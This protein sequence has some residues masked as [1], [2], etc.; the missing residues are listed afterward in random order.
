LL[1]ELDELYELANVDP[2]KRLALLESRHD[3]VKSRNESFVREIMVLVLVGRYDQAIAHLR[4][5]FFHIRE[6]GGEIHDV[7]VDAHLLRGL[8]RLHAG[9]HAAALRDFEA[10]SE[11]PQNLS[12]GRP[13]RDRRAPQV[14]YLNGLAHQALGDAESA[15][16]RFRAAVEQEGTREAATQFYQG[17][18]R[19]ALGDDASA[20]RLFD[21]LVER[22]TRELEQRES[23][24]FFAKFGGAES[25][26][27]R[28][29]SAHFTRGLG[30]LGK[31]R[32]DEAEREFRQAVELDRS[33]VWARSWHRATRSSS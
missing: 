16:A 29:A 30:L 6:G 33:H 15:K 23:A 25:A 28:R 14:A 8:E 31:G 7:Y 3:V 17:L 4:D 1:I 11:Y 10:A 20:I 22:G 19:A 13:K 24:D 12:V 32:R 2:G 27:A 26:R 18:A 5:S 9:E 21:R